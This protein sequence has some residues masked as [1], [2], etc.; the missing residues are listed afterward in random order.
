MDEMLRL[1][2]GA[3]KVPVIDDRGVVSVG[4]GGT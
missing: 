1:S 3:R 2:K 4:Y